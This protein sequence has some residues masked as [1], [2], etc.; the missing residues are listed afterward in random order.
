MSYMRYKIRDYGQFRAISADEKSGRL[1]STTLQWII[2][3]AVFG[4]IVIFFAVGWF[5]I[6]INRRKPELQWLFKARHS[7]PDTDCPDS[8]SHRSRSHSYLGDESIELESRLSRQSGTKP[9][10]ERDLGTQPQEIETQSPVKPEPQAPVFFLPTSNN[11]EDEVA[12]P[13]P[14]Y[15][16]FQNVKQV[17]NKR[18]QLQKARKS[19]QDQKQA[20]QDERAAAGYES[21]YRG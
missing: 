1:N 7:H 2:V 8:G 18:R 20:L 21:A 9:A 5:I 11:S 16:S 19:E 3:A 12:E 4:P 17:W 14:S 6:R 15:N 10:E 13:E